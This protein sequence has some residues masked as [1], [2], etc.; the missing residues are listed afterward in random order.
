MLFLR[1]KKEELSKKKNLIECTELPTTEL[2]NLERTGRDLS[3]YF[4]KLGS[5]LKFSTTPRK[6]T[7][8]NHTKNSEETKTWC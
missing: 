7:Y 8:F 3:S 4:P 6:D 2:R 5:V 1:Q